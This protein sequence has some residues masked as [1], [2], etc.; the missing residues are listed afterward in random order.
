MKKEMMRKGTVM[1]AVCLTAAAAFGTMTASAEGKKIG[2]S[3][4]SKELARSLKD[5]EYLTEY[6]EELGYEVDVQF[7]QGDANI[8]A[9]QVENMIMSGV[10]GLIISPWDGSSMTSVV[11][12]AHENNIPAIAYDAN[13]LNSEYIDY[14]SADD[15]E[16][17]GATQGRYIVEHLDLDNNE[18]TFNLEIVAGDPADSNATY[19]Y[20]GAMEVLKPY[21]EDGSLNVPS[22]QIEFSVTGTPG[23]EASK[24][25]TR[26]DNILSTYYT[27]KRVDAVLC[28][29]DGVALGVISSLKSVGYGA[30]DMPLPITTGQDCDVAS[31]KSIIAGEQT[32][33]VFKDIRELAKNATYMIDCLVNGE[34]PVIEDYVIYNNGVKDVIAMVVEPK[35]LDINNYQEL[36]FDSGYYSEDVLDME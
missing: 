2:I 14:Y 29:N 26:M 23:W 7:G 35:A 5:E 12:L 6:L 4:S 36:L 21:I 15:L 28:S 20:N 30:E 22:G 17:I 34:E 24:A 16:E 1:M 8:Q 18:D 3:L 33:T 10:D 32:M 19:F 27:D 11:Q 25:Q 31:I 9:S 13:I